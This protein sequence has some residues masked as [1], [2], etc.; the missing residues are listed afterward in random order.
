[1]MEREHLPNRRASVSFSFE[2]ENHPYRATAS[3]FAD[4]RLGEIFLDTDKPD[5]PLQSNAENSAILASIGLQHGIG[6]DVIL[7]SLSG[8]IATAL[9][10]AS[11]L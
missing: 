5:T 9:K 6:V 2:C 3:F 8:P 11:T 4:G 1:M 10:I 7:H